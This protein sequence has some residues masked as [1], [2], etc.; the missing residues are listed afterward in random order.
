M[1][2]I[3]QAVGRMHASPNTKYHCLYMFYFQ[4]LSKARLA[5][6]FHKAESTI[7]DWISKYESGE[8]AELLTLGVNR[9]G[10]DKVYKT[11]GPERRQWLVELYSSNPTLYLDEAKRKYEKHYASFISVSSVWI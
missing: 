7:A 4:G 9:K 8:G 6:L 3:I 1:A 2:D 11:H 5:K 10:Q